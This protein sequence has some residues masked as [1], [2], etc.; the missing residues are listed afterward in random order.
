MAE[1]LIYQYQINRKKGGGYK[2]SED[3]E[4]YE[5][6]FPGM[7]DHIDSLVKAYLK[8][9]KERW[10]AITTRGADTAEYDRTDSLQVSVVI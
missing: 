3:T 5:R 8:Y 7:T 2:K 10:A 9:D 1:S 4:K 6:I